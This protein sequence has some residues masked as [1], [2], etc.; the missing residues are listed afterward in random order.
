MTPLLS[1]VTGTLNRPEGF[2]RLLHSV[3]SRTDVPF[4]FIVA[5][6]T[7]KVPCYTN[8]V[9]EG[10]IVLPENPR[11]GHTKGYNRAFRQA[12][13]TYVLW[14]ND[15][16]EVCEGYAKKAIDFM[17][18]NPAIGLGALPYSENGGPFHVNSAWKCVYANFGIFKRE[19][20]ERIGYF[21][22][23]IEMYGADNSFTLRVLLAG[24]GVSEVPGAHILHHSEDD[25]MRRDN[26]L[27][28][29][30]DNR[31]LTKKY[32][33][34]QHEWVRTFNRYRITSNLTPWSHGVQP[35]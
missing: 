11:L 10:V 9:P 16:A 15:D 12:R 34:L 25:Q 6:A 24:K 7:D 32:M 29:Q 5:D 17:D 31:V 14:L 35:R 27:A 20:G 21:D 13:G 2:K 23:D 18:Q 26:Q 4:E 19:F 30:R 22:E 1:L 3:M 8:D 33:P 28:R